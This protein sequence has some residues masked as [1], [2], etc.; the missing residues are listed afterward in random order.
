MPLW[1]TFA[2]VRLELL[3]GF[4]ASDIFMMILHYCKVKGVDTKKNLPELFES[5][6]KIRVH[7]VAQSSLAD[8]T[9]SRVKISA[10]GSMRRACHV[11]DMVVMTRN[12]HMDVNAFARKRNASMAAT[13]HIQGQRLMSLRLL[14]EKSPRGPC[15]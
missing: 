4:E 7:H 14:L 13:F 11:V 6:V 10:K 5:V 3:E 8:E 1:Y 12:L 9:F 2:D 15:V